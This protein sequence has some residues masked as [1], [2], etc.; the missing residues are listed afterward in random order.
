MKAHKTTQIVVFANQY[1]NPKL[2]AFLLQQ[3][4]RRDLHREYKRKCFNSLRL[5]RI[6]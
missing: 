4:F 5:Y 2:L 3:T 6:W 1:D